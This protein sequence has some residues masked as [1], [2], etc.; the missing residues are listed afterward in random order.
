MTDPTTP[1]MLARYNAWADQVFFDAV[2]ALPDGAAAKPRQTLFKTM[3]GTLNHNYVVGLI[4]QA[5]L[6]RRPHG[7][8]ARNLVLHE[9]LPALREAQDKLNDWFI[10]WADAQSAE[11]FAEILDFTFISGERGRMTREEMLLH[12]V[13]HNSYHRGWAAEMFFDVPAKPPATDLP[14]Y[15]GTIR[16]ARS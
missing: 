12:V 13:N 8:K 16:S 4:W 10:R 14:V 7:L 2:A 15:L 9:T 5:H 11:S 3:I 6:E 1:R